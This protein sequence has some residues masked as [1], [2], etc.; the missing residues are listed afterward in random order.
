MSRIIKFRAW[1]IEKKCMRFV[2]NT[3]NFDGTELFIGFDNK[4]CKIN[5]SSNKYERWKHTMEFGE[6]FIPMQF[7][8]LQDKNGKDIYEGDIVKHSSTKD[9]S[10]IVIKKGNSYFEAPDKTLL[11]TVYPYLATCEVKVVGNIYKNPELLELEER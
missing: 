7:I 5:D 6:S 10:V 11:C 1:D 9:K 2:F 4:I 3:D 8:G